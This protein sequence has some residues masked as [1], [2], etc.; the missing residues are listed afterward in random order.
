MEWD[1]PLRPWGGLSEESIRYFY[2]TVTSTGEEKVRAFALLY[3]L[4]TMLYVPAG[5]PVHV[6]VNGIPVEIPTRDVP[7]QYSTRAI[8][9]KS[10]TFADMTSEAGAFVTSLFVGLVSVTIGPVTPTGL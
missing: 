7:T 1:K 8:P 2:F 10:V 4:A 6:N 5:T 3:A 9:S